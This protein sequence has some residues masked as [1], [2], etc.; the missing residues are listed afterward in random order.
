[1]KDLEFETEKRRKVVQQRQRRRKQALA[2]I[3][4]HR[5]KAKTQL[6]RTRK[7]K[8]KVI[9]LRKIDEFEHRLARITNKIQEE[10]SY[11]RPR[12]YSTAKF[13]DMDSTQRDTPQQV[14]P[15]RS[16]P[17]QPPRRS[18]SAASV[19]SHSRHHEP[20]SSHKGTA[21][22]TVSTSRSSSQ[23]P[24][25]TLASS[26]VSYADDVPQ[27]IP[28][29]SPSKRIAS[30][31]PE[32]SA[33][34]APATELSGP[35]PQWAYFYDPPLSLRQVDFIHE[36]MKPLK[37]Y[38]RMHPGA[39]ESAIVS[40]LK[41]ALSHM[42]LEFNRSTDVLG[43]NAT[44]RGATP[45][46]ATTAKATQSMLGYRGTTA[47]T[48]AAVAVVISSDDDSTAD[49]F[50]TRDVAQPGFT[51]PSQPQAHPDRASQSLAKLNGNDTHGKRA[52]SDHDARPKRA[53][54]SKKDDHDTT[55]HKVVIPTKTVQNL[56]GA[57]EPTT[58][59]T[60]VSPQDA[61]KHTP[62]SFG[63][64]LSSGHHEARS[65]AH[66]L[67][68]IPDKSLLPTSKLARPSYQT[69]RAEESIKP[70]SA[71]QDTG[72]SAV[73]DA[74]K[75]D[76]GDQ[77]KRRGPKPKLRHPEGLVEDLDGRPYHLVKSE[78]RCPRVFLV[79]RGPK[80]PPGLRQQGR[81]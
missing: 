69:S 18:P 80:C 68:Q 63:S 42:R 76:T 40:D 4:H 56:A 44:P 57:S 11:P 16:F 17:P 38:Q 34:N 36:R 61:Q 43:A 74:V 21:S 27:S 6:S 62:D 59:G 20:R 25:S 22:S 71:P 46:T 32:D 5:E 26:V 48:S 28:V 29:S 66:K 53:K 9:L 30:S 2:T 60:E 72:V 73:R 51:T 49:E 35:S 70:P 39:R 54:T 12:T 14:G 13:V 64:R 55:S 81:A 65:T 75:G 47:K 79:S 45:S 78:S 15:F 67:G 8:E 58:V 31:N 24:A 23:R 41:S 7:A 37:H 77:P 10:L 52:G 1:M 19:A 50:E 33:A 3:T